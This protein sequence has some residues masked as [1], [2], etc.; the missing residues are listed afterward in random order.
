M[1]SAAAP[2]FLISLAALL[3]QSPPAPAPTPAAKP[4]PLLSV[5]F[6]AEKAAAS[7]AEWARHTGWP[8]EATNSA[9]MRLLLIPPGRF[10]MGPNGSTYRVALEKPFL[11]AATEVTLG[12]YRRFRPGH[13][14]EGAADEFNADDHPA[15]AV[16]WDDAREFCRWLSEEPEEKAAGRVYSLPTEAQWEWAARAGTAG[17]AHFGDTKNGKL[18]QQFAV[19]NHT[20]TPNPKA[21]SDGRGRQPVGGRKP[22]AFGL[23]DMLGNVWEW[24]GDRRG[25]PDTGETRDPV[26]RG[27][28]WRSGGFHCTSVA[29]DPAPATTRADNVGFRVVCR[30][31]R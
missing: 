1:P 16:S 9:G 25:D 7:R 18:H 19:F 30:I 29:F 14:V 10:T 17:P 21:E 6:E 3:G 28:S 23:Y 20:Y 12:Q 8:E 15:A 22:N 27:G 4:P 13:R 24:C 11:M 5:P 2:A 26:M 31:A